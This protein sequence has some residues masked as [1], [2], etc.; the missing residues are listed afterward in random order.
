MTDDQE[1][2]DSLQQS[3][4]DRERKIEEERQIL[5]TRVG[6]SDVSTLRHRVAWLLNR[7]PST[8][9]SDIAL[10][11]KHWETFEGETFHGSYISAEDYPRLTRLTSIAR[12]RARIQNQ[13]KLFLADPGVREHRGTLEEDE[14]ETAR[15]IPDHPVYAVFLDE[16]GKRSSHLIVGSL[17]FLSSG[18]ESFQLLRSTNDLKKRRKFSGEFH[19][20]EMSKNDVEAYKELIDIFLT[21]GG[22]ISF[23]FISVPRQGLGDIQAALGDLYYHL[24]IKGIDHEQSTGRARLPRILQGWKDSEELGADRLLMANLEDRLKQAA[25]SVYENRL[26]IDNLAAVN[27]QSSIFLQVADIMASSANR[28]LSRTGESRNHKDQLAEYLLERLGISLTPD[29]DVLTGDLAAHIRI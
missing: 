1:P 8:R 23:K 27:S 12:D 29:L 9:N 14:R 26:V 6:S 16:S 19:F 10:Q 17:W 22:T 5:L 3:I 11:L 2:A 4:E 18:S 25:A 7:Y 21:Q 13:Y 28:I 20:A 15:T 24:L